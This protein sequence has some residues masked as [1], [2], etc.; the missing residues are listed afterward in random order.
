MSW[1]IA[2][3]FWLSGFAGLMHE[4]VWS[5][6]LAGVIGTTAHA[7]A[8]VL[9]VYMGGLALG[10][11]LFGKRSDSHGRSLR[12]YMWLE[13][14]I[15]GYCITL[16]VILAGAT[17]GYVWLAGYVF[18]SARLKFALRFALALLAV[19]LPAV[20]MGGTLPLLARHVIGRPGQAR[21]SVA[22]LYTLNSFGAVAGAA[23]AGFVTLPSL[24]VYASLV[25]AS[26]IN[27]VA[28]LLVWPLVRR[29]GTPA[30]AAAATDEGPVA[31][32]DAQS[33][34]SP[35]TYVV[36]LIALVFGGFAAMGY[37]V[38]FIRVIALAFGA[39]TYSFTVML[40]SF[41]T[42][43]G[44][45]SLLVMRL[46]IER[47]LWL[48]GVSQLGAAVAFLAV[49]P[50]MERLP[51][52]VGL[53]RIAATDAGP[54]FLYYQV[55]KAMLCLG[56]LLIP[57]I[58]LGAGFPLVAAIQARQPGRIG[59]AVGITY[60][61]NTVGNVLGI[62]VT[63]LVLLP[64]LGLLG[65]FHVNVGLSIAA[66][67]MVLAVASEVRLTRP[68]IAVAVTALAVATYAA[69]GL[70][71]PTPLL[72]G[73]SHMN[74]VEGPPFDADAATVA[75]HPASSFA[76][77]KR[78]FVVP[79]DADGAVLHLVQEAHAN[80]LVANLLDGVRLVVNTKVDASTAG[81]D[82]ETQLLL[83][84]APLFMHPNARS[85]LVV[86]YGS[87]ITVG[88]ALRHPIER[89]DVVEISDGVL[90]VD[91]AFAAHNYHALRDPRLRV[92]IDDA[93]SFLRTVPERYDL[94]ISE[95]SNPWI[96]GIAGLFTVEFFEIASRKLEPGGVFALWFH[97]YEQSDEAVRL[98]V[99]TFRSVFPHVTLFADQQYSDVVA[100]GSLEP[101]N[102][103]PAALEERFDLPEVRNDLARIGIANLSALLSHHAVP[104]RGVA[105]MAGDGPVNRVLQQRLEYDAVRALFLGV[106]SGL[107]QLA[108]P[109][110]RG[111][112][113]TLLDGYIAYRDSVGEP[114]RREE[115]ISAARHMTARGLYT[116][117]HGN[118]L[119]LRADLAPDQESPPS[120]PARGAAP[121]PATAGY[122]EAVLWASLLSEADDPVRA[123][124]YA[125]RAAAL[126]KPTG[127]TAPTAAD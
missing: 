92:F 121:D 7:Q 120:R 16:P 9:V 105:E 126:R 35:A 122:H 89:A 87:G 46:R 41:I 65:A 53:V 61:C 85:V 22:A 77:W 50:L 59:S 30:P 43:I 21:R 5:K 96:S 100:I 37:E 62:L 86:G 58:C 82:L 78:S 52:Y 93:Q 103:D 51:Y 76:N 27:V 95:P 84:H 74:L 13:L 40:M 104:S 10:A 67:L 33:V 81:V 55:G 109:F 49:T 107:V 79:P 114:V 54:S 94:I 116:A 48:F 34:Y 12:T 63:T 88:S 111:E 117:E 25:L 80:V 102:L 18:E 125:Q 56:V 29:D 66:G 2:L 31:G 90:R 36:T 72:Y 11:L 71:W 23:I 28:A 115:F 8:A 26:A 1:P 91:D 6:L 38:V 64:S 19:V 14:A 39:T 108:S 112:T 24:G 98:I 99:R 44:L 69:R 47:P 127:V 70:E 15:A 75:A 113:G 32:D 4:I 20:M 45:G 123:A 110:L 119:S 3:A 60:A 68:A 124:T 73:V 97:E 101:L 17:E 83:A 106:S 118:A 42:G 57:T